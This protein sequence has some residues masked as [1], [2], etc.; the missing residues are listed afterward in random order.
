MTPE[1]FNALWA[2][3][4]ALAHE[5]LILMIVMLAGGIFGFFVGRWTK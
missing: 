3:V 4:E 1:T 2:V 5:L